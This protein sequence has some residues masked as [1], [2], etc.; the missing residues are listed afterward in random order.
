M[1]S[2]LGPSGLLHSGSTYP[3][4][5]VEFRLRDGECYGWWTTRQPGKEK[6]RI[7]TVHGA[8]NDVITRILLDTGAS[9]SMISLDL[10]RKL[11]LK[12]NR[13]NQVKVVVYIMEMWVANIGEGLDVLLGMDFIFVQGCASVFERLPDEESILMYD[14]NVRVPQSVDLPVTSP[15]N[16][17][18]MPGEHA[19]VRIQYGHTNPERE[20]VWAGRGD[21]WVTKIVYQVRS[22]P[23]AIKVV[24]VSKHSV[25]IDMR[26]PLARIAHYG[27][28][29]QA[30][31]FV[32]PGTRAYGAIKVVNVSKHSVWIDMRTPLAR[33]V[34]YG[35]F[36]QA[37]CFVRPGTRAY[38][39]W[40]T[41]IL[42]HAQ[43]EQD[44][45]R[46][47]TRKQALR[48]REP[49]CVPKLEYQ[50][51]TKIVLRPQ[52]GSAEVRMAQLQD[53]PCFKMLNRGKLVDTGTQT[54]ESPPVTTRMDASTQVS[55]S[56]LDGPGCDPGDGDTLDDDR[57]DT[58]VDVPPEWTTEFEE[59]QGGETIAEVHTE[60][61]TS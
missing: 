6:R 41:L 50:W 60:Q 24:N 55:E 15:E 56:Q 52:L 1:S 20:V 36:P 58:F 32:R 34:Q 46:A 45:L 29:P 31:R 38:R 16:L 19:V 35:S 47:E 43:S 4:F 22:W 27:S 7:A 57:G 9:L 39:E 14:E 30:G 33:I 11:K 5:P 2:G 28:F 13:Q 18:L 23:V 54:E 3:E 10:A 44:R 17:Y 37:G 26:T 25:W 12:L 40:Q 21:R 59:V 8:V 61:D 53:P 42:E 49:P 48:D 51:P